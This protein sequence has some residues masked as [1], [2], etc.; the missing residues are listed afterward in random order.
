MSFRLFVILFS[1]FFWGT[2]SAQVLLDDNTRSVIIGRQIEILEDSSLRSVSDVLQSGRFK[3]VGQDVPNLGIKK[4]YVWLKFSVKNTS[5]IASFLLDV[6]YPILDEVVLYEVGENAAVVAQTEMGE[7]KNF[8]PRKFDHPNFI[9]EL[10]LPKGLTKTYLLKIKSAEQIIVPITINKPND[11]WER[12]SKENT[13]SGIYLGIVLIMAF[14]NLFIFF[15]VK[16]KGYLYY[17]IYVIFVGLTQIGIKGFNYEFLWPSSPLFQ[18]QSLIIF[19]CISCFAVLLFTDLFLRLKEN[20]RKGRIIIFALHF[21]YALSLLLTLFVDIQQGFQLML[22]TTTIGSILLIGLSFYVMVKGYKPARYFFAAWTVLLGGSIVFLLKDFG[23]LPFNLFTSYSFQAASALE[24]ALLSFG[25]A[26]RINI[27][28][29]EKEASQLAALAAAKENER[30]IMEQNVILEEK[31]TERTIELQET[32]EDLNTTLE[33]L[34]QAQSQ[35]VEA[36]KMAS[37]GQLTAGIAHE[38]NNPINFVTSN[39]GPLKRDVAMVFDTIQFIEEISFGNLSIEEKKQKIEDYKED[40][41]YDYL[42][43]EITHLLDGIDEGSSRTAEIVKGLRIFSRVDEHDLKRAN[44]NEGIDSTLIIVNNQLNSAIEI[45]KDY[46]ETIPAIECYPGKLN[47]VFLNI[48]SNA[49]YAVKKQHGENRTGKINISTRAV[50]ENVIIKIG[51]N[52]IGMDEATIKNI[53]EPFYTTKEVGEGTGLGLSIV[54][55]T[56]KKHN[57]KISVE[58]EPGTGTTFTIEIPINFELPQ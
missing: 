15:S 10:D 2:G 3:P 54:F 9:F 1:L 23:V 8:F 26:D 30:I 27:L 36:E 37:L 6:A 4:G 53:F 32:N 14:Y 29:K 52:G 55:N 49:I 47:Q 46:S 12:I 28:K 51:D 24:M 21:F 13:L 38:I 20:A 58:S 34:K 11:L 5:D 42:K 16:D 45:V 40:L 39:V 44:V 43:M 7:Y 31:V 18:A 41:D 17:V 35:L 50:N 48:I 33:D 25:L 56:I 22:M 57:G 19:S